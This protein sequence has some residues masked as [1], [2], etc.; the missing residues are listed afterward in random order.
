MANYLND[1]DLTRVLLRDKSVDNGLKED[2]TK[3]PPRSSE[4]LAEMYL[5]MVQKVLTKPNFRG[6]STEY[7]NELRGHANIFFSRY[8]WKFDPLRVASNVNLEESKAKWFEEIPG[9]A[10]EEK[11]VVKDIPMEFRVIKSDEELTG[12]FSYFSTLI[13]S[14][15]LG[16]L[17]SLNSSKKSMEEARDLTDTVKDDV[18][19][20][21]YTGRSAYDSGLW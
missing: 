2:G 5:L 21:Y 20:E 6:Y 18:M 8:W 15:F 7:A 9:D 4:E 11:I 17:K 1:S 10:T 16:G 13:F 12:A 19:T 3:K 14:A